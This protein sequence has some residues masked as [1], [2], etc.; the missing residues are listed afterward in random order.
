MG[1]GVQVSVIYRS[2]VGKHLEM[3]KVLSYLQ[4][5]SYKKAL[6]DFVVEEEGRKKITWNYT[7]TYM[8][9]LVEIKFIWVN[10]LRDLNLQMKATLLHY[11]IRLHF[12]TL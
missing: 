1:G 11:R 4:L 3:I 10:G 12:L 5:C 9:Y 7:E 8:K 6:S 2:L